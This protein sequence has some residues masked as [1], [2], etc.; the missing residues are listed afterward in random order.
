MNMVIGSISTIYGSKP[1]G[2]VCFSP[3]LLN[4]FLHD[5][6]SRKLDVFRPKIAAFSLTQMV[7]DEL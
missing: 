2:D 1:T 3:S 7:K 5:N 4:L 6:P